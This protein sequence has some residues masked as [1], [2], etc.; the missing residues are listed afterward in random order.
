MLLQTFGD[1]L[2]CSAPMR[3]PP[4]LSR[5]KGREAAESNPDDRWNM[6]IFEIG[7]LEIEKLGYMNFQLLNFQFQ[8]LL[9]PQ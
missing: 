2:G 6:A 4:S 7:K 1:I 5:T 9:A 3:S 8:V